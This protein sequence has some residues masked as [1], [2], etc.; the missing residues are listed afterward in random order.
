MISNARL[1]LVVD[2]A[3]DARWREPLRDALSGMD[4][5]FLEGP[6]PEAFDS[7]RPIAILSDDV[8]WSVHIPAAQAWVFVGGDLPAM[9]AAPGTFADRHGLFQTSRNLVLASQLVE[10]GAR[11]TDAST[12][13]VEIEH[14]GS[15]GARPREARAAADSPLKIYSQIPPAPGASAYWPRQVFS[16]GKEAFLDGEQVTDLTGRARPLVYG[17]YFY[18]PRGRWRAT[19]DF[20]AEPI[21]RRIPLAIE[22]GKEGGFTDFEAMITEGGRYQLVLENEFTGPGAAQLVIRLSEPLFD[23]QFDFEGC[24][25]ERLDEAG[26]PVAVE[27]H[28]VG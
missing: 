24:R 7:A 2:P 20:T 21:M 19:I 22:W 25:V 14:A 12:L 5:E 23:G 16:F 9:P 26:G 15:V 13:Q 4:V 18:L 10:G 1:Y 3:A 27:T 6:A 17:P 28:D 11:L 8:N